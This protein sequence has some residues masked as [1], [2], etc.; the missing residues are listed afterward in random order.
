MPAP[1]LVD[2]GRELVDVGVAVAVAIG[3]VRGGRARRDGLHGRPVD[4]DACPRGAQPVRAHLGDH[5]RYGGRV[6]AALSSR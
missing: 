4:H 3:V 2:D 5:G 6:D 1:Q